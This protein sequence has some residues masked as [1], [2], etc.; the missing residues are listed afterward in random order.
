MD[1]DRPPPIT[2]TCDRDTSTWTASV[3]AQAASGGR[4]VDALVNLALRLNSIGWPQ[5][6]GPT[7]AVSTVTSD[8]EPAS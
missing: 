6:A 2:L 7:S 5:V 3:E 1:N 8:P 4:P